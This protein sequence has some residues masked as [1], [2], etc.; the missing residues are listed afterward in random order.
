MHACCFL[1]TL[2][3]YIYMYIVHIIIR[4]GGGAN[5]VCLLL[6]C[7]FI[8]LSLFV[9]Q[10]VKVVSFYF[11]YVERVTL[12]YEILETI[13]TRQW[14]NTAEKTFSIL[15]IFFL[16]SVWVCAVLLFCL[17]KFSFSI[18]QW[19]D[20]ECHRFGEFE[21]WFIFMKTVTNPLAEQ[22]YY[23]TFPRIFFLFR[24][25]VSVV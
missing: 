25:A 23:F 1:H 4:N 16:S 20:G 21:K 5:F 8:P 7:S 17:W 22:H 18:F 9:Y 6:F 11:R 2:F 10:F 24:F 3:I 12:F 19:I 14:L 15:H 13:L